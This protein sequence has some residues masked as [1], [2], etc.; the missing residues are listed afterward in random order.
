[1]CLILFD[2][3]PGP[4]GHLR[5]AANRD[6]WFRRP[7]AQAT[8]WSDHPQVLAGRD[9]VDGGTWLGCTRTGRFAALTNVR[10]PDR[11]DPQAPSR[12]R[13]VS[14]FLTGQQTAAD[15]AAAVCRRA[16]RYNG[17]NLLVHDGRELWYLSNRQ[18][19]PT[20]VEPGIHGLSND[21]LNTPWPK[22]VRG[23]ERFVIGAPPDQFR[24]AS[25]AL[26][27][28]QQIAADEHLPASGVP[29]E[30]ERSLSASHILMGDPATP[31]TLYGTRCATVLS[32]E[33]QVIDFS[34]RTFSPR[35]DIQ[36]VM[37]EVLSV[38]TAPT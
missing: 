25:F 38:T 26:L 33:E 19:G 35:A 14:D 6:E 13:L 23:R 8:F 9:L 27:A 16:I 31:D 3:A 34:E 30:R 4:R 36:G 28:D 2:Y 1:M 5:V 20:R 24:A 7:S 11:F 18:S 21:A 29:I 10:E 22:V 37:R 32:I 15:Y 12:G 17:Y